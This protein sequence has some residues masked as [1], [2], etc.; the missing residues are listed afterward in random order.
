MNFKKQ[1][2]GGGRPVFITPPH[3]VLGGFELDTT[4]QSLPV[5][6][7]IPAGTLAVCDESTRKVKLLK[8]ARVIAISTA[9]S[10]IVTVEHDEFL[11][12][13]F[14]VG[15]LVHIIP[16]VDPDPLVEVTVT[17]VNG[18]TITLSAEIPDLEV[19][20]VITQIKKVDDAA[21]FIATF[22]CVVIAQVKVVEGINGIDVSKDAELY[23][24]RVL[25]VPLSLKEHDMLEA[26][27]HIRYSNSL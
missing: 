2:Y 22:N 16:A 21:A 8:S 9:D 13:L 26:N 10:K 5:G 17:A 20:D 12:N 6:T 23:A 4:G 7:V 11:S 24:R 25:P 1:S 19:G 3:L 14:A 18:G 27:P 15:D